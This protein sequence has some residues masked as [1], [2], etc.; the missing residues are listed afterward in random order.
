MLVSVKWKSESRKPSW[1]A[2]Q[3]PLGA[4]PVGR[5]GTSVPKPERS[6]LGEEAAPRDQEPGVTG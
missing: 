3:P 2:E 4:L 5:L 1:R 6:G